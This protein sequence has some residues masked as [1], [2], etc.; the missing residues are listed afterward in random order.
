MGQ[1]ICSMI[2]SLDGYAEAAEGD[3]G[4]GAADDPEVHTFIND[5]FRPVGT[6]LYGRRMYETMVYWETAHTAPD[7][8]PHVRQYADDWQAADKVVYST[9]LETVASARTRIER[10]FD[11]EKVR[12]LKSES[13]HDLT[14]DGP[15][16]AAQAVRA[17]LVDEYH[18]FMTSTAVG[19]G[20]RFFPEGVRLELE[21]V[22][23]RAFD[24]GLIYARYRTR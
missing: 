7:L 9:T 6:Y 13:D 17:G 21:L 16:L 5:L 20:K 15:T 19:G 1:L 24:S 22:E 3:L 12:A 10:S 18:L 11:P 2:T 8:P 23:Q 14:V 4:T